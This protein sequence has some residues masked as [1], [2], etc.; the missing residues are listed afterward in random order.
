MS[1]ID[2]T[3]AQFAEMMKHPDDGP[4][5]MLNLVKLRELAAYEDGRMATGQEAYAA[6]GKES[7]PIF[8]SV[9]GKVIW[10]GSPR[11][12]LIGPDQENW[13]I[14]FIAAYPDAEAFG[15]MV[16]D[17]AYQAIVYHRQAAVEDSR[18]IRLSPSES[19]GVFG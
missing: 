19:N 18:L 4:V 2:P 12:V 9:G 5:H 14:C 10:S 11:L 7:G 6:Y 17:P 1:H 3:R 13:D 16:K 15:A 8:K